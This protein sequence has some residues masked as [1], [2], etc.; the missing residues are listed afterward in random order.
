MKK[1]VKVL[2][3]SLAYEPFL[4][5]AEIAVKEITD[6][7]S[8]EEISFDMI[9]LRFDSRLPKFEKVGNI[10]V[11]RIGLTKNNPGSKDMISPFLKLQKY[12]F[13][14]T[15]YLKAKKLHRK[16][17]YD[18]IWSIMA[19]FS[20]FAAM[21]FKMKYK[22]VK[23]LLTLQE[24]DPIS[25]IKRKVSFLYF[26]FK[27]IFIKANKIQTI[28]NYL[29]DFAKD[30]GYKGEVVVVPNGVD[31][32]LFS[33]GDKNKVS[34]SGIDNKDFV[35]ITASRLVPKN[36][37][38]LV[39]KAMMKL[40]NKFKFIILGDGPDKVALQKI[41]RQNNLDKRVFF[42][43]N[44]PYKSIPDYFQHADI[45]IRPSR[46]EGMGNAFIEAFAAGL[47]VIATPV[48]GI[49]DFLKDGKT[50]LF[51]KPESVQEI[52][53]KVVRMSLN[54]QLRRSLAEEGR[55]LAKSKYSWDTIAP[56]IKDLFY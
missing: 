4:G 13:P 25:E 32:S 9:T 26:L 30:M 44:V 50:G 41:V 29:K 47:P 24:G 36:G 17:D 38:D 48:G 35:L 3:F 2:I 19:N 55:K 16:N 56:Q 40:P 53:E 43:G 14:F 52:A 11:F 23:F 20:G 6:R 54:V 7:I 45:F 33:R 10:N 39:L 22:K 12:F 1:P 49:V 18:Y 8:P 5:G 27:K 42:I 34:V 31:L 28:S 46:S 21:F 15:A 51:V 37:I